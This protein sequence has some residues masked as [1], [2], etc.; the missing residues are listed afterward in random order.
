MRKC[1][2]DFAMLFRKWPLLPIRD[3]EEYGEAKMVADWLGTRT[4]LSDSANDYI[5]VL[6][7]I[8]TDYEIGLLDQPIVADAVV[9]MSEGEDEKP[10][11][12][13]KKA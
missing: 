1:G 13:R 11:R 4:E 8:L 10:K 12:G 2:P 9:D 7:L 3:N 5:A 6:G